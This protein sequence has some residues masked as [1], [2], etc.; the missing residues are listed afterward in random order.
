VGGGSATAAAGAGDR[1]RVEC[2]GGRAG[3][4][5]TLQ[6]RALGEGEGREPSR[7]QLSL[8]TRQPR[9]RPHQQ[10]LLLCSWSFTACAGSFLSSQDGGP[11]R[12]ADPRIA[13]CQ[14]LLGLAAVRRARGEETEFACVSYSAA[15]YT[16]LLHASRSDRGQ[17]PSACEQ[18]LGQ[19]GRRRREPVARTA[20]EA[21]PST[22]EEGRELT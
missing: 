6:G 4:S 3:A 19:R 5:A 15:I 8:D 9:R 18:R 21:E 11:R 16:L 14:L 10:P 22:Q 20:R 2:A 17:S 13:L 7:R 12:E 1:A